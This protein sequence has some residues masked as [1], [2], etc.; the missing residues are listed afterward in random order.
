MKLNQIFL[1]AGIVAAGTLASCSSDDYEAGAP[2]TGNQ[3]Q[4]VTFGEDNIVSVEVAPT[5]PTT[6]TFSVYRDESM[7][8]EAASV[9][10]KVITNTSD[11]F[12]V[13]ATVNFAAGSDEAEV[14][15]TYPKAEIG[16]T[17]NLEVEIDEAYVN[18]YKSSPMYALELSRVQWNSIGTGYWWDGW[19]E[20]I[21]EVEI[22][23]RDDQPLMY[24]CT[25]PLVDDYV[26]IYA[27]YGY[28]YETGTYT[29]YLVFTTTK[30]GGVTWDDYFLFNTVYTGYGEIYAL[31][32]EDYADDS[33]V[34][35]NE[36][37]GIQYLQISPDYY[38]PA[39][40]YEFGEYSCYLIFPGQEFPESVQEALEEYLDD[41]ESEEEEGEDETAARARVRRA[42]NAPHKLHVIRR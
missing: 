18:P 14:T 35:E 27:E 24:R 33:F 25:N 7:S 31:Y 26:S 9:P 2:A 39:I 19:Y 3:L 6:Y 34:Q 23:Q 29:K 41:E 17:Y 20:D 16:V 11:I 1:L 30:T 4:A 10:L 36:E 38:M 21:F 42:F 28:P 32:V 8:A 12:E 22:Q 13:P 15:V 37:G 40:D 5:D